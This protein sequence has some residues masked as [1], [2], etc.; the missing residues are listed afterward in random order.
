M[1][2]A[3]R[4]SLRWWRWHGLSLSIAATKLQG[5]AGRILAGGVTSKKD[6]ERALMIA[7]NWRSSHSFPLNT[8]QMNLRKVAHQCDAEA[9]IAQR[10]KRLPSI[11]NKLRRLDWLSLAEM[12]D[13]GG[14]RAV[15]ASVDAVRDVVDYYEHRSSIK[16]R[17]VNQDDYIIRP[18]RSGYRSVHLI[19]GYAS[20][21]KKTY[22]DLK[23]EM[24]IRSRLQ[25]AWATAVETVD[26]FTRQ[27][28]K[29]ST[30]EQDWL[31]FFALISSVIAEQEDTPRIPKTPSDPA[32]LRDELRKLTKKLRVVE[33][34]RGYHTALEIVQEDIGA[35]KRTTPFLVLE[36]NTRR[37]MVT[38]EAL[39]DS[40][41]AAE[42]YQA[43]ERNTARHL[44]RDAVLV[45]V[46]SL[47]ALQNA[48]PNY[49][50][51]TA[52]F[53]EILEDAIS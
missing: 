31:R 51:D 19:F 42:R 41:A 37:M 4:A 29:S 34:L 36:L 50:A 6:Y 7:N 45:R 15:L 26:L 9:L 16:H 30:G 21:R 3:P 11:E 52:T 10:L 13:L 2:V 48:Y 1:P 53:V 12:Q 18:K 38:W 14:C 25:H 49:F 46:E 27:A 17:R 47:D 23:I 24:Q 40:E 28:L 22:N 33:R 43:I 20:D 5:R 39:A 8:F 32:E 44:Y 35:T